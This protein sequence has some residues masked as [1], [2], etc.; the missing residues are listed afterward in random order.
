[1]GEGPLRYYLKIVLMV[2]NGDFLLQELFHW[3]AKRDPATEIFV[4]GERN[5]AVDGCPTPFSES[6]Y[7]LCGDFVSRRRKQNPL[8]IEGQAE[9]GYQ[10]L[11]EVKA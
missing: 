8:E 2:E 3:V 9:I 11:F 7:Q 4:I 6:S 10:P 5:L 1:M